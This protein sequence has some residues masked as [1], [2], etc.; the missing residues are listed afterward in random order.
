MAPYPD[1]GHKKCR[2]Q[3]HCIV[4]RGNPSYWHFSLCREYNS[5]VPFTDSNAG[6]SRQPDMAADRK[7]N[8]RLQDYPGGAGPTS[9]KD[10]E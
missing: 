10:Q 9:H 3:T 5:K 2:C 1:Q 4:E 8:G 7:C 6:S